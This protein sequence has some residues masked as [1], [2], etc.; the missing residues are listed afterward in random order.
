MSNLT[1]LT[2]VVSLIWHFPN[3]SIS[4]KERLLGYVLDGLTSD[5]GA[6]GFLK[7]SL[8]VSAGDISLNAHFLLN[9]LFCKQVVWSCQEL[10]VLFMIQKTQT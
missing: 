7:P 2:I 8:W 1:T 4:D 5:N 6:F 3:L 9:R 10:N